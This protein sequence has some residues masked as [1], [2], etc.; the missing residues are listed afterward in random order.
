MKYTDRIKNI[1]GKEIFDIR[2]EPLTPTEITLLPASDWELKNCLYHVRVRF[3]SGIGQDEHIDF[4]FDYDKYIMGRNHV[5][6][7]TG[8]TDEIYVYEGHQV[9]KNKKVAQE[10]MRLVNEKYW[11]NNDWINNRFSQTLGNSF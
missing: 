8:R 3:T 9:I 5:M 7:V 6:F 1:C 4:L 11:C 2:K 10:I